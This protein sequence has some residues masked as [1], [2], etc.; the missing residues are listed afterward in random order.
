MRD[1]LEAIFWCLLIFIVGCIC[2]PFG[3]IILMAVITLGLVILIIEL[4][5]YVVDKIR[6]WIR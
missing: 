2:I 6:K 1:I 4:T 5:L 3:C